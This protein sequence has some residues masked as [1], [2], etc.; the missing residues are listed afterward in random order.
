MPSNTDFQKRIAH[1][2]TISVTIPNGKTQSNIFN[3]QGMNIIAIET[4]AAFTTA[5]LTFKKVGIDGL[6]ANATKQIYDAEQSI[7]TISGAQANGYYPVPAGVFAG[8]D[9]LMVISSASQGAARIISFVQ[10][11]LLYA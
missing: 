11:P 5:D 10:I 3:I 6:D 4:P 2:G 8:V 1:Q 7:F 9:T